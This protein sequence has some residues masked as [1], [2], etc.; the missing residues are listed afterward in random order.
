M[1]IHGGDDVRR[2]CHGAAIVW[3]GD[4]AKTEMM[5]GDGN[6]DVREQRCGGCWYELVIV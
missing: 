4:D 1:M 2:Q 3:F 6:E 5:R